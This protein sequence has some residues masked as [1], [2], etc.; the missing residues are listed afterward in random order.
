[1]NDSDLLRQFV[2]TGEN[3]AFA[4]L[5]RQ[6]VDLV[7]A[8][9]LRHTNGDSHRAEDIAQQV[10]IDLARKAPQLRSH[11]SLIGWL[12]TSV[13]YT[14]LNSLRREHRR[15]IHEHDMKTLDNIV[16][17]T[18]PNWD[19]VRPVIDDALQD[20]DE[21]DRQSVLLRF[22]GRQTFASIGRQLGLSENAAQKRTERALARLGSA[23]ARRGI[24][25]TSAALALALG[26]AAVAAP[27][28]LAESATTAALASGTGTFS[29]MTATTIKILTVSGAAAVIGIVGGISYQ[30]HVAA[31]QLE[32][33]EVP[34]TAIVQSS[35]ASILKVDEPAER[36]PVQPK[37]AETA[38]A[39]A[40][41][42][43]VW[44]ERSKQS[45]AATPRPQ[46]VLAPTSGP[47]Y[48]VQR[49]DTLAGIAADLGVSME[50]VRA[51]NPVYD[52]SL[53]VAGDQ[54]VIPADAKPLGV[55]SAAPDVTSQPEQHLVAGA[56]YFVSPDDT[57]TT[58]A[59]KNGLTLDQIT[60]LNPG[61]NW[62]RLRVGQP[63]RV[64]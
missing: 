16:P 13:R 26:Q 12:Y 7:Y 43:P 30:K 41:R 11:P 53:M 54:I 50:S 2:R 18:E 35:A 34:L 38:E 39:A 45:L 10:F 46:L 19:Q 58:I 55:P 22:F 27:A 59:V 17:G 21:C 60:W 44:I 37:P 61:T 57:P 20:L 4:Q 51:A 31:R 33:R 25:S 24:T 15:A 49:G 9:A 47:A 40:A 52:F 6:H 42:R 32:Q 28:S 63:L 62:K 5:V 48:V 23:L 29:F 14:A 36:T 64:R 8:A 1:M 3:R 56:T